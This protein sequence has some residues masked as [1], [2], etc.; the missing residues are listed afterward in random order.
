[1]RIHRLLD[2]PIISADLHPSIGANI[3]GASM[4]RVPDWIGGRLGDYYLYFADH[5]GSYTPTR[6][7]AS[8]GCRP[9][10]VHKPDHPNKYRPGGPDPRPP[11]CDFKPV[12]RNDKKVGCARMKIV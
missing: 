12:P 7:R 2:R 11:C 6:V 1:M 8:P 9:A 10:A 3:Q 4:I 5:K